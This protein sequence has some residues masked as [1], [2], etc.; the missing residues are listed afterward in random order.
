MSSDP[1]LQE[2]RVHRSPIELIGSCLALLEISATSESAH[3]AQKG[4]LHTPM[5]HSERLSCNLRVRAH[6][7]LG[8]R[9]DCAPRRPA[10]MQLAAAAQ[11][12]AT[13][14]SAVDV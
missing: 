12:A 2:Y 9:A 7:G 6:R 1:N 5:L 4:P 8:V 3:T 14:E 11:Q 13:A 10:P